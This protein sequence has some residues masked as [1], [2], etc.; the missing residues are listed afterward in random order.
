LGTSWLAL[1]TAP[2]AGRK[3]LWKMPILWLP[4][5][6]TDDALHHGSL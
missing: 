2:I 5:Q 1:V 4:W 3:T 6:L